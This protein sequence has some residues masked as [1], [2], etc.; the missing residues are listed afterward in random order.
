[1]RLQANP[2]P[3]AK[4]RR[5]F[6]LR[7]L[8]KIRCS[9]VPSDLG[10]PA[11]VAE[12]D[13][14]GGT[15]THMTHLHFDWVKAFCIGT[16]SLAVCFLSCGCVYRHAYTLSETYKFAIQCPS[17]EEYF[18]RVPH[19]G[20]Y[21]VPPDGRV[22]VSYNETRKSC[23]V[24]FMDADLL[25]RDSGGVNALYIM[26]GDR[27][28]KRIALRPPEDFLSKYSVDVE[29]YWVVRLDHK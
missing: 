1:M 28:V 14:F 22:T 4:S 6:R 19:G 5:A 18:I 24:K 26:T 16:F 25:Y 15:T 7:R 2:L 12:R 3:E 27:V 9:L 23:E 21:P 29:G 11:A 17:P 20:D 13:W 8:G 10:S